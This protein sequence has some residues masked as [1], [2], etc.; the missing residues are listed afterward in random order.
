MPIIPRLSLSTASPARRSPHDPDLDV[1][2]DADVDENP[3]FLSGLR[4]RY[5]LTSLHCRQRVPPNPQLH[6]DDVVGKKM[7]M[8]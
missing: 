7:A 2:V 8:E 4:P 3:L 1:G 5:W 6:P